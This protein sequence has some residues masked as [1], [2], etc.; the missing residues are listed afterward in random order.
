MNYM[1][2]FFFHK[3]KARLSIGLVVAVHCGVVAMIFSK[4]AETIEMKII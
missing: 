3:P 4:F 2:Y 1:N